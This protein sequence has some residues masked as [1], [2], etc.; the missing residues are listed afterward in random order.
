MVVQMAVPDWFS[1]SL[2]ES[3][4][5]AW[6]APSEDERTRFW[7]ICLAPVASCQATAEGE[8]CMGGLSRPVQ[9]AT[10]PPLR[11]IDGIHFRADTLVPSVRF[12]ESNRLRNGR[13]R[14]E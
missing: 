11:I 1:T 10:L 3:N 5:V 13:Q 4:L 6:T 12:V 9:S 2:I 7:A 8:K 14:P